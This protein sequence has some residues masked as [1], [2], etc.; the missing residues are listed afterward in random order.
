MKKFISSFSSFLKRG[1]LIEVATGLLIAGAFRDLVNAF[2]E[3]FILPII[4][5]LLPASTLVDQKL[6]ILGIAFNVGQFITS[7]ISFVI[8]MFVMFVMINAYNKFLVKQNEEE[9]K[10]EKVTELSVLL[11]IKEL[12][13]KQDPQQ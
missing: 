12:L 4:N 11:E 2:S 7:L 10:E 1:S 5:A 3:S 9:A 13:K 6:V 8:I